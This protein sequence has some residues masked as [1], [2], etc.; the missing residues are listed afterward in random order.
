MISISSEAGIRLA[1]AYA[2]LDQARRDQDRMRV[3]IEL[4]N[5]QMAA[6]KVGEEL[7][8]EAFHQYTEQGD[9]T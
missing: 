1:K 5:F 9:E 3:D 7:M 6:E 4:K 2:K 8:G